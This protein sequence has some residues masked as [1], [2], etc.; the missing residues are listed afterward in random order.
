[1]TC[2]LPSAKCGG[3]ALRVV[4]DTN[5][6]ISGLI[7]PDSIPGR[8]VGAVRQGRFDVVVSWP[9][10]DEM[11]R[12]ARRPKIRRRYAISEEDI[13]DVVVLLSPVLPTVEID[14]PTRDPLDAPVVEAALAGS[15]DTIVTGDGDLLNDTSLREWL[16]ER[17]VEV[18]TAA[19]LLRRLE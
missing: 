1:M 15:A 8:V 3:H 16:L 6:W 12:V 18:V 4:V 2:W 14:V 19:E 9:L 11:L 5:I 7:V 10:V 17:G 13:R